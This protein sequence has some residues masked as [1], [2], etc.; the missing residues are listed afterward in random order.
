MFA[1]RPYTDLSHVKA[2]KTDRKN[3]TSYSPGAA[4]LPELA[5]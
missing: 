3:S 1:G 2:Q 5:E 4:G